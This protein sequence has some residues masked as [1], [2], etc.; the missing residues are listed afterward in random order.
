MVG[1]REGRT[2][3]DAK[4]QR[5]LLVCANATDSPART[6]P[7]HKQARLSKTRQ[8]NRAQELTSGPEWEVAPS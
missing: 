3:T 2:A 5:C 4:L 1:S 6:L 8:T 7:T